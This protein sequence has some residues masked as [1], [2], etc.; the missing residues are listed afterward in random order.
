M[1]IG[2]D[3]HAHRSRITAAAGERLLQHRNR[4]VRLAVGNQRECQIPIVRVESQFPDSLLVTSGVKKYEAIR[5]AG[6]SKRIKLVG[7]LGPPNGLV[8]P[9]LAQEPHRKVFVRP[10]IVRVQLQGPL[11]FRLGLA[12]LPLSLICLSQQDMWFGKL[13]IQFKRLPSRADQF[14]THLIG[15]DAGT[16]YPAGGIDGC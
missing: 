1:R 9:P 15:R 4:F 7:T 14:W 13:W 16:K 5:S 8:R 10:G 2:P 12:P 6:A 11:V 3:Q